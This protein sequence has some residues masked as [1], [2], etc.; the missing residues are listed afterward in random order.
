MV[1][2]NRQFGRLTLTATALLLATAA[3]GQMAPLTPGAS[4][5]GFTPSYLAEQNRI[6]GAAAADGARRVDLRG[7]TFGGLTLDLDL[8]KAAAPQT[9]YPAL[10]YTVAAAQR[11]WLESL[12]SNAPRRMSLAGRFD[13][14]ATRGLSFSLSSQ[15]DGG[16]TASDNTLAYSNKG[17]E[18]SL[19]LRDFAAGMGRNALMS[20]KEWK[21]MESFIG[22][23]QSDISLAWK[24]TPGLTFSASASRGRNAATGQER[25]ARVM[26]IAWKAAKGTDL[27]FHSDMATAGKGGASSRTGT[28]RMGLQ[29]TFQ[30]MSLALSQETVENVEGRTGRTRK[31]S[32]ATRKDAAATFR[33]DFTDARINGRSSAEQA[34]TA[35]TRADAPNGLTLRHVRSRDA[36]KSRALS[37]LDFR[38]RPMATLSLKGGLSAVNGANAGRTAHLNF[39]WKPGN[40]W[41]LTGALREATGAPQTMADVH[42]TGKPDGKTSVDARLLRPTDAKNPYRRQDTVRVERALSKSASLTAEASALQTKAGASAN[43]TQARLNM[44]TRGGA[45]AARIRAGGK[46]VVPDQ[47]ELAY[48]GTPLRDPGLKL[49]ARIKRTDGAPTTETVK[50]SWKIKEGLSLEG[51]YARNPEN[52]K[53]VVESVVRQSVGVAVDVKPGLRLG[54]DYAQEARRG[55][56]SRRADLTLKGRLNHLTDVELGVTSRV[57]TGLPHT[58]AFRLAVHHTVDDDH[59]FLLEV[60]QKTV[61]VHGQDDLTARVELVTDF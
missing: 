38:A 22:W 49:D 39:D 26:D 56:E 7:L 8:Q 27:S 45:I 37:A 34:F 20:D 44:K 1:R 47:T 43:V 35:Q 4:G 41:R 52:D 23:R 12:T 54:V 61:A 18:A 55:F 40:T 13:S 53:G 2:L 48:V 51:S 11:E 15:R 33:A 57:A 42:L 14:G 16:R 17:L 28:Q 9:G 58:P 5:L 10:R 36:G 46:T 24:G 19:R 32:L 60:D 30:G 59:R 31:L 21:A 29:Q 3:Q 6:V 25:A 50:A